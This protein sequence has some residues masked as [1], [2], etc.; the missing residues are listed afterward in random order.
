MITQRT[1]MTPVQ[2]DD[3]HNIILK[4]KILLKDTEAEHKRTI[5]EARSQL[6]QLISA[7]DH[8]IQDQDQIGE[9]IVDPQPFADPQ[10]SV[11]G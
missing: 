5:I 11:R 2:Q 1:K 3:A 10:Q 6:N 7:T 8:R 4:Y 9:T